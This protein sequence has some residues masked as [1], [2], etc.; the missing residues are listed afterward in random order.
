MKTNRSSQNI[1]AKLRR[2]CGTV[3]GASLIAVMGMSAASAQ[4]KSG[5]TGIDAS[6]NTQLEIAACNSGQ[7]QQDRET[8]LREARNASAD[9]RAGKLETGN[10]Q[11]DANAFKRCDALMGEDKIACQARIAG[12]GNT[13][14]SVSGGGVIRQVETVVVPANASSVTVQPQTSAETIIVVPAAK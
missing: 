9:K 5:T 14:G 1:T 3:A 6:G 10:I 12:Y 4:I 8:C 11:L 7:T 13:S 2:L